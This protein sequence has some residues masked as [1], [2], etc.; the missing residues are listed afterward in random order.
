[1][2]GHESPCTALSA[3]GDFACRLF[4]GTRSYAFRFLRLDIL[5]MVVSDR[6][7]LWSEADDERGEQV[8][9]HKDFFEVRRHAAGAP[10]RPK[11]CVAHSSA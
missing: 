2:P 1:M 5:Q 8:D 4:R 10:Y 6:W 9:S 7:E 3:L 11:A